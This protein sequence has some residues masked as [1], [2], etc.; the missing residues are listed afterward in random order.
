MKTC[1]LPTL[2]KAFDKV[3]VFLDVMWPNGAKKRQLPVRLIGKVRHK[4]YL[5][6]YK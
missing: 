6:L 1:L 4:G 3:Y 2:D 5:S